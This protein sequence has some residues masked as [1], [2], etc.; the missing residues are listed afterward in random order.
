VAE[1][2]GISKGDINAHCHTGSIDASMPY[3]NTL[4]VSR[5]IVETSVISQIAV[6]IFSFFLLFCCP[7]LISPYDGYLVN[8]KPPMNSIHL[9]VQFI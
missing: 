1:E 4:M 6:V 3:A 2:M 7:N 5:K 8:D 9:H